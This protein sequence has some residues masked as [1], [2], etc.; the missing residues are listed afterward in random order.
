MGESIQHNGVPLYLFAR[1]QKAPITGG[2]R[3]TTKTHLHMAMNPG[4]E[5]DANPSFEWKGDGG[6]G[7]ISECV[8]QAPIATVQKAG[9]NSI[10]TFG[11]GVDA[12][13]MMLFSVANAKHKMDCDQNT[14]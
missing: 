3:G 10:F 7:T 14:P 1:A 6:N 4:I 12:C 2:Y 9:A 11:P 5:F 13:L 8:S